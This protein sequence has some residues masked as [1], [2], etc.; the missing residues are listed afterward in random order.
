[1]IPAAIVLEVIGL[2]LIGRNDPLAALGLFL[3][4]IGYAW[5]GHQK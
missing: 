1:M 5:E 2:Y 4:T 3:F